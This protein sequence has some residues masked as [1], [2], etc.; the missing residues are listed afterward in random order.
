MELSPDLQSCVLCD[1]V[2]REHNG[3]FIL[4]GLFDS[5]GVPNVPV[6]YPRICL[7]TRW[8]SG[9]G[10][11]LQSSRILKPDRSTPLLEGKQIPVN[12]KNDLHTSTNVE[13]FLNVKFEEAGVYWV[14]VYLDDHLKISYPLQVTE[15][16]SPATP[17]A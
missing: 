13:F 14:E 4:I 5:L 10:E 12:L 17:P 7:A 16:P 8:C 6:T 15:L 1:D 2:R 11:F 9:E 3:K